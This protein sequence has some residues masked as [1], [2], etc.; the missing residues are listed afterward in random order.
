MACSFDPV[1]LLGQPIGMLHCPECGEMIV[2]GMPHLDYSILDQIGDNPADGQRNP[3]PSFGLDP[4]LQS[5]IDSICDWH[6]RPE[7]V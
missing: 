5:E 1:Q 7:E 2:A 3:I 4:D 6:N